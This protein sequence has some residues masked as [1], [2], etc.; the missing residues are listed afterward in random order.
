M[1]QITSKEMYLHQTEAVMTNLLQNWL[2]FNFKN[3]LFKNL[4][5]QQNPLKNLWLKFQ[6]LVM[7]EAKS[8]HNE[9]V[10]AFI[11]RTRL[12]RNSPKQRHIRG[13]PLIG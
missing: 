3:D 6:V 1:V 9:S 8:L 13:Q 5:F 4:S 10:S 12:L 11:L 7:L 2:L